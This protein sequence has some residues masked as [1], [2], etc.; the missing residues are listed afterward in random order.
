MALAGLGWPWL[1]L[2]GLGWPWLALA[3][4]G[5]PWLAL[6]FYNHPNGNVC[7][8]QKIVKTL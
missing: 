2:A 1:A 7:C 3:G 5:W 8:L 4:L 6:E